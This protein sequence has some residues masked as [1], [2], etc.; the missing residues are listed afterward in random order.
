MRAVNVTDYWADISSGGNRMNR[1]G[2]ATVALLLVAAVLIGTPAFAHHG[3]SAYSDKLTILK[4]GT[5]TKFQWG[6]PHSIVMFDASDDKGKVQHWAAEAGSPSALSLI[7]WSKGAIQP[8][9]KITVYMFQAKSGNPVGRLNKVVL[10]DGTELH[11]SQLGGERG[12]AGY[13]K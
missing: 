5:V 7:G 11:D 3:S 13:A 9:D 1:K 6:N 8:G 12:G 10:S 4:N 2:V